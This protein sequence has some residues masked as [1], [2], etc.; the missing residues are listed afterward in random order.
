MNAKKTLQP[1]YKSQLTVVHKLKEETGDEDKKAKA[2]KDPYHK[3]N[4]PEQPKGYI[5]GKKNDSL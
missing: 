1:Y 5:K 4:M 3:W 2:A